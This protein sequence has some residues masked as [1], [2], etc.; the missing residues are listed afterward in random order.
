MAAIDD[1]AVTLRSLVGAGKGNAVLLTACRV[2]R[3]DQPTIQASRAPAGSGSYLS[4]GSIPVE[5]PGAT[6]H[7]ARELK[8]SKW[9]QEPVL[10]FTMK[11]GTVSYSWDKFIREYANKWGGAH[12]DSEIP[13]ELFTI[14]RH[15]AAGVVMSTYLLRTAGVAVWGMVQSVLTKILKP[16]AEAGEVKF[17]AAPGASSPMPDYKKQC[18]QLQW[19]TLSTDNMDFG[20]YVDDDS[21]QNIMRLSFGAIP[22]DIHYQFEDIGQEEKF[23]HSVPQGPRHESLESPI[24]VDPSRKG[25]ATGVAISIQQLATLSGR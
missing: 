13:D 19:L 16:N 23:K 6:L 25:I 10:R 12:F 9:V 15:A 17:F 2:F 4:I 22:Y 3:L 24:V 20:W 8:L 18:G 7:G 11:S 1:L 21:Q 5:E 14:D